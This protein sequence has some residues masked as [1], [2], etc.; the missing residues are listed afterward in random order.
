MEMLDNLILLGMVGIGAL[1]L[2]FRYFFVDKNPDVYD[3]Q[4]EHILNSEE[5]KVK[6]RFE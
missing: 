1:Y 3:Q 5:Y 4:V 6:G 2:F